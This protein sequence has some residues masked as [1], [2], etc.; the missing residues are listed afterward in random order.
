MIGFKT[1]IVNWGASVNCRRNY[2]SLSWIDDESVSIKDLHSEMHRSR[3]F[4]TQPFLGYSRS[5][6]IWINREKSI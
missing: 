4:F 5:Y 2:T 1:D 6:S 3:C